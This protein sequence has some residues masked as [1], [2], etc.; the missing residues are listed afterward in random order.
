MCHAQY[1]SWV[2]TARQR[3]CFIVEG[4]WSRRVPNPDQVARW[5]VG[6]LEELGR[7]PDYLAQLGAIASFF[8]SLGGQSMQHVTALNEHLRQLI[9]R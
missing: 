4:C 5:F 3:C 7:I 9:Q 2:M 8:G 6:L 1:L